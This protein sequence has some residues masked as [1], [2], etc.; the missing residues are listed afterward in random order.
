MIGIAL[1]AL[2][3]A[4]A[5]AALVDVQ[6]PALQQLQDVDT[7]ANEAATGAQPEK[8]KDQ[9]GLG[10]EIK[11][12]KPIGYRTADSSAPQ[13]K[14]SVPQAPDEQPLPPAQ[15]APPAQ[16]EAKKQP[17]QAAGAPGVGKCYNFNGNSAMKGVTIYSPQEDPTCKAHTEAPPPKEGPI[18]KK[19]IYGALGLGAAAVAAGF[20]LWPPALLIGGLLLGAGAVLWYINKKLS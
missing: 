11:S 5:R 15:K 16:P 2:V 20:L 13:D 4:P 19:M 17:E 8:A 12:L 1:M 7:A 18:S 14:P 6:S 9:G 10:F 3:M